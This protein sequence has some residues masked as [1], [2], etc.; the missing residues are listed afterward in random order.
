MII[1]TL[2]ADASPQVVAQLEWILNSN[3]GR[4]PHLLKLGQG[5]RLSDGDHQSSVQIKWLLRINLYF[6]YSLV[7]PI[8]CIEVEEPNPQLPQ[9]HPV[10]VVS[11]PLTDHLPPVRVEPGIPPI[12]QVLWLLCAWWVHLLQ[13]WQDRRTYF[14]HKSWTLIS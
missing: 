2:P 10:P 12:H 4:V 14:L 8:S 11:P 1:L 6:L 9:G 13:Y 3:A 7:I 5:P